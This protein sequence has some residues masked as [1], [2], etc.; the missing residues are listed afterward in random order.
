MLLPACCFSFFQN[1]SFG[2]F[3]HFRRQLFYMLQALDIEYLKFVGLA[4]I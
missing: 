1:S 4:G 3:F 2:G